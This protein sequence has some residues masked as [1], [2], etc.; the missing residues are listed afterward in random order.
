MKRVDPLRNTEYELDYFE[1]LSFLLGSGLHLDWLL[2]ELD[3]SWH[4]HTHLSF[5]ANLLKITKKYSIKAT[6]EKVN[7]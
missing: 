7:T 5:F 4:S 2:I 3:E 6:V 1:S